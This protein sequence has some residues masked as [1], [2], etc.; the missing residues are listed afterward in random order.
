M[1]ASLGNTH[2]IRISS[3]SAPTSMRPIIGRGTP[4]LNADGTTAEEAMTD[5]DADAGSDFR[6]QQDARLSA[7]YVG[8]V[9]LA[10]PGIDP[11]GATASTAAVQAKL[12]L[13]ASGLAS[14]FVVIPLDATILVDDELTIG[15]N[16]ITLA[17]MGPSS[18]IKADD[19]AD[20]EMM[21]HA[22][23]RSRVT[24]RDFTIEGNMTARIAVPVTNRCVGIYLDT[25]TDSQILNVIVS[26]AFG[27]VGSP[28]AAIALAGCTRTRVESCTV[29]DCGT[30]ARPSDGIY[31]S[32]TQNIISN[33]VAQTI[34]DTAFVIENSNLSGIEGCTAIAASALAAITNART[35]VAFGNY[36]NGLTGYD[37]DAIVTGGVQIGNPLSSSTGNLLETS[38]ANVLIYRDT[39]SGP[40]VNVRQTGT[41]IT[42]GLTFSNVRVHGA[43]TQG[44]LVVGQNVI[45]DGCY[46]EGTTDAC[47]EVDPGSDGVLI[48]NC[49]LRF[50]NSFGIAMIGA[51]DN[52]TITNNFIDGLG[53]GNYGIY[54]F[55]TCA[56][57]VA[58]G[59]TVV[60]YD[61]NAYGSDA[62]TTPRVVAPHS[63]GS[64]L[65]LGKALTAGIYT[66]GDQITSDGGFR[67]GGVLSHVGS[68]VGFYGVT[69]T[70]RPTALTAT[71]AAAPAGGTGAAAGGWDTA[72]NRNLAIATI[73]NLK[74]RVD[75]LETK[76]QSL[77]LLT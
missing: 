1:R 70:I 60:N 18:V 40:A 50:T 14:S 26:N 69:P 66:V 9:M 29:L 77:G 75:Q 71:V 55:N 65:L 25:C 16:G 30:V 2:S 58:F 34:L 47:I 43:G 59:N 7:S 28:S 24:L 15:G 62:G 54:W 68:S 11:T 22:V 5:V 49:H 45:I 67:S 76:L 64:G 57:A 41:A 33:C 56:N 31:T 72:A 73:N 51:A 23:G 48:Q 35:D 27:A 4:G 53:T 6:S 39:G 63:S 44:F 17:G 74:T 46:V 20:Y 13:A 52:V 37:W 3:G 12:T 38:V 42:K 61:V 10:G 8:A 36:I 32:G 21:I 19:T